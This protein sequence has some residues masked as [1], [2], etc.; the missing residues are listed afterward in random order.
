MA[1]FEAE[2]AKNHQGN[3][4]DSRLKEQDNKLVDLLTLSQW[5]I[6]MK[7][8]TYLLPGAAGLVVLAL[9]AVNTH[10]FRFLFPNDTSSMVNE[11]ELASV[12]VK[13]KFDT[14]KFAEGAS[15]DSS[16]APAPSF[17]QSKNLT[18]GEY[19]N[20]QG[21]T[22]MNR[23]V[24]TAKENDKLRQ[25][26]EGIEPGSVA[27]TMWL[28]DQPE[29]PTLARSTPDASV[30][31]MIAPQPEIMPHQQYK[32]QGQDTFTAIEANPLKLTQQNPVSTFSIDVDT[33]SYSFVRASLNQNLLPPKDAVRIEEL[34]N[35]FPYDYLPPKDQQAP[36][37]VSTTVMPNP[38]NEHTKLLH[39]GIKGYQLPA[40]TQPRANL[41]FL[42]DTSGSMNQPNKLPLLK[43]SFK[44]LLSTLSDE[45]TVS[46]VSYAGSAGTVLEPTKVK[47]KA[48][49]LS[50]LSRLNAGGSTSGGEGIRLAYQLAE[51]NFDQNG[52]NRVILATDGDFNVGIR[53]QEEL[54]GF[55]ERK[56]NSGVMLSVLG[57]GMGNYND[58][59]MQ[60]LAQNGNGNAAYIDSLSEARK[61]LVEEAS[62]TLFSIA[63][64]VKI[65]MEFNPAAVSEYRLIG[66]ETRQL[67]REDF[68][69]DKVD[70]GD[71]GS[72]HSVTAIYEITPTESG[73]KRIDDL[74][75]QTPEKAD[76]SSTQTE[77]GFLKLRYKLPDSNTSQLIEQPVLVSENFDTID[78]A[79]NDVRFAVAVAAFG[80]LLRGGQYTA[81]YGYDELIQMAQNA[82]GG[83]PFGYRAEFITLVRLAKSADALQAQ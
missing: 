14:E 40:Q 46:I 68:N 23:D 27:H 72:G 9:V 26:P 42:L 13:S 21:E 71:I 34:I 28:L 79:D 76:V 59:L 35:Y 55:I 83:D 56:R 11:A 32:E 63:K 29:T 18:P 52:V 51:A 6:S 61:V 81:E 33:A 75:Y 49:I 58:A 37:G 65:Q 45:D 64:D 54:K 5:R 38:W 31:G 74:R 66:Y 69:N 43:N 44:L 78:A 67:K 77:Y 70:A 15:G 1:A 10:Q 36:F 20:E 25:I 30:A 24:A 17:F 7:K 39:I 41:V 16:T 4:V 22:V 80:Q 3:H 48:A 19:I 60:T 47:N 8:L 73:G 57:F 82:K 2:K 12:K 53:N 50:A 62:S